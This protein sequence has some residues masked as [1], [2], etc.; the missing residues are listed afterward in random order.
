M[1]T[2]VTRAG[3]GAALTWTEADANFTNLNTAKLEA[4]DVF[5]DV[6]AGVVPAS[7]GGT[8]NFLRADGTFAAPGGGGTPGGATT[9][10]QLNITGAFDG[11][12]N[13]TYDPATAALA[14]NSAGVDVA[15]PGDVDIRAARPTTIGTGGTLN[16]SAG[17][18]GLTSGAGGDV[19][20]SSGIG[21]D[22]SG[23]YVTIV[24]GNSASGSAQGGGSVDIYGGTGETGGYITLQAGSADRGNGNGGDVSIRP[25]AGQGTGV[26]GSI[27][28][29]N[30][31]GDTNYVDLDGE[32]GICDFL[33]E[34]T[35]AGAP[36][37]SIPQNS[38]VV[39]YTL[40]ATD[41]GKHIL[42]PA[43]D[44]NLRQFTIPANAS[45]AFPIGT[46]IT[47]V[48]RISTLT[49]AINSDTLLLADD[50]S[51]GTRTLAAY[52]VATAIKIGTTEW[53]ISGA[54]LT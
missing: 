40:V 2:I 46:A 1:T 44:N 20:I 6:A 19:V 21:I 22:D 52:G 45:V 9:E 50:G 35:V 10:V 31:A 43:S 16:L 38:Q 17:N 36:V 12:A 11:S 42:H 53:I 4:G 27:W 24:G 28:L 48:N 34:P 8:T 37:R 39:N 54:G 25:G 15:T 33:E 13:F 18:G 29:Q 51:T 30:A 23:G 47:F 7:G 49:I 3:K 14:V 41:A 26:A 5:T 32:T